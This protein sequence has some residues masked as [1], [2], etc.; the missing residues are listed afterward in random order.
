MRGVDRG[1][2][3]IGYYNIGR[4]SKSSGSEYFPLIECSIL[5]AFVLL[6]FV[7]P[8]TKPDLFQLGVDVMVFRHFFFVA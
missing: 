2:Q 4:R 1:D 6:S 8:S 5:N 3:M 7:R